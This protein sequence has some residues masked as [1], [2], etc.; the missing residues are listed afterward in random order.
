M[1]FNNF[2][3]ETTCEM[4]I[5]FSFEYFDRQKQTNSKEEPWNVSYFIYTYIYIYIYMYIKC[6]SSFKSKS[7]RYCKGKKPYKS[8]SAKMF[9]KI[10]P[11][12]IQQHVRC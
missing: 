12:L 6:K 8:V 2:I 1:C 9:H 7:M 10:L 11:N 3:K 5:L 4:K